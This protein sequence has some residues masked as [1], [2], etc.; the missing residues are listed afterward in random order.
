MMSY[1]VR[2]FIRRSFSK[3]SAFRVQRNFSHAIQ[4]YYD[5]LGISRDA[6]LKEIKTAYITLC[7]KLHPDSNP[8]D[9]EAQSNFV[10]LNEA[11]THLSDP[12]KR[13]EH[14]QDIGI[15]YKPGER[16][17]KDMFKHGRTQERS[18]HDMIFDW[19]ER[20]NSRRGMTEEELLDQ[21][22]RDLQDRYDQWYKEYRRKQ[23]GDEEARKAERRAPPP[24]RRRQPSGRRPQSTRRL[25]TGRALK[26]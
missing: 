12:Q 5:V 23:A 18:H 2:C 10:K 25:S 3:C 7:K 16:I 17:H 22:L 15:E 8:G 9:P 13:L 4:S 26:I 19:N 20:K 11:Y 21:H 24:Q 6:S 1:S 14:N